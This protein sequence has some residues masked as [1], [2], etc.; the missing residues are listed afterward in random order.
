MAQPDPSRLTNIPLFAG[1]FDADREQIASWLE[2]E[3]V[4]AGGYAIHESRHGYAFFILAEGEAHAEHAGQ[5]LEKLSP[6]SVFGEMAFFEPDSRRTAE[7][8]AD[9]DLTVFTMFGT[10]FREMQMHMPAVAARLEEI[11]RERHARSE[12]LE[13]DG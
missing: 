7:V 1:L 9:S 12:S 2:V 8:L 5:V 11:F 13:K 4:P 10:H 6:G 3:T